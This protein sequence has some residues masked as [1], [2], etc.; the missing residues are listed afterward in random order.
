LKLPDFV[1]E[2]GANRFKGGAHTSWLEATPTVSTLTTMY[3]SNLLSNKWE[4]HLAEIFE[5][6]EAVRNAVV[7]QRM[8][9]YKQF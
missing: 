4:R 1:R 6:F 8:G 9:I 3:L 2:Q 5:H 7:G